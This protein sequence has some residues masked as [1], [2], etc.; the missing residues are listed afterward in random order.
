MKILLDHCVPKRLRLYLP[1]HEVWTT[2]EMGWATLKNG[3]LLTAAAE[4]RFE[5]T[6]TVDQNIEYQQNQTLLPLPII[7]L[8]TFDNRLETLI[9]Y[10]PQIELALLRIPAEKIVHVS[11]PK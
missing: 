6:I 8:I 3:T 4:A 9:P 11:A 2:Y 10:M 1:R 5:V 7:I